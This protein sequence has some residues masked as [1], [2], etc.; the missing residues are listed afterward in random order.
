MKKAKLMQS[1]SASAVASHQVRVGD[2]L[3]SLQQGVHSSRKS[4]EYLGNG[5]YKISMRDGGNGSHFTM[6]FKLIA[7]GGKNFTLDR[8]DAGD[9]DTSLRGKGNGVLTGGAYTLNFR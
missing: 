9:P 1:V 6:H 7:R 5:E 2:H 8:I 4:G 3:V